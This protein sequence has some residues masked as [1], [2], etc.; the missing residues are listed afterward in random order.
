MLF[1]TGK[2]GPVAVS[3]R[4]AYLWA[5]P[6]LPMKKAL[7]ISLFVLAGLVVAFLGLRA[8]T[9]SHSPAHTVVWQQEG[10]ALKLDYSSP[11]KKGRVIFGQLVP[12]GEVWRTG[13]NEATVLEVGQPVTV[14]GKALAAGKYSLWSIP[15]PTEWTFIFNAETG[16]WGTSYD[17]QRD[18]LRVSVPA[19]KVTAPSERLDMRFEQAGA[20]ANLVVHWEN[21]Q[22]ALPIRK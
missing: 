3:P 20:G 1:T 7:R 8:W 22:V 18:V 6:Y 4:V 15:T 17:A 9:K 2:P 12:Y 21:T 14:A 19:T 11:S 13:A 16:Q 5:F 10:L